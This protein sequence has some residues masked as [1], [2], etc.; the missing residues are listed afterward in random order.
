[1]LAVIKE[2]SRF[3]MDINKYLKRINYSNKVILDSQTLVGLHE[4]HV[5]SVPFEKP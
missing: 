5:N 1:M 2:S 3:S 4:Y